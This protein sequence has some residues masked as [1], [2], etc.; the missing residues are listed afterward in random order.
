MKNK[1][2]YLGALRDIAEEY[3]TKFESDIEKLI[4]SKK[5]V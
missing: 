1:F 5:G 3:Y 4:S 2:K